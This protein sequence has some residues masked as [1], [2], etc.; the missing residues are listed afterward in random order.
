MFGSLRQLLAPQ[1]RVASATASSSPARHDHSAGAEKYFVPRGG[2]GLNP[3]CDDVALPAASVCYR[4]RVRFHSRRR[5][6]TVPRAPRAV[7]PPSSHNTRDVLQFPASF[8]HVV[9][10]TS[11]CSFGAV[12]LFASPAPPLDNQQSG[13]LALSAVVYAHRSTEDASSEADVTHVLGSVSVYATLKQRWSDLQYPG[14]GAEAPL[15]LQSSSWLC[16]SGLRS[17]A[18]EVAVQVS[19]DRLASIQIKS[20]SY[21]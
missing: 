1:R 7:R 4:D 8:S 9:S 10:L 6:G 2:V 13:R 21:I 14:A 17:C 5:S 15:P 20:A 12:I 18:A 19:R 16:D 11:T 3:L